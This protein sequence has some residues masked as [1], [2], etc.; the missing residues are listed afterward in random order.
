MINR[1]DGFIEE[2]DG[3][4]YLNIASTGI[5]SGVIKSIRKFGMELKTVLK[6]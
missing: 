4:K 2:K 1:I 3:D 6:K 5:N